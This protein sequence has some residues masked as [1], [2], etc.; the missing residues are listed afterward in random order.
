MTKEGVIANRAF[1]QPDFHSLWVGG[2]PM[3]TPVEMTKLGVVA[4]QAFLNL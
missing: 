1:L 4:N 2:R 3:N